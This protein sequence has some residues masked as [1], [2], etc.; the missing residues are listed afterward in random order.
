MIRIK[1]SVSCCD[2]K[3]KFFPTTW[4][5]IDEL[6]YKPKIFDWDGLEFYYDSDTIHGFIVPEDKNL[7]IDA[8]LRE[9]DI[10]VSDW[11]LERISTTP[12]PRYILNHYT[13][14]DTTYSVLV[15][16]E[17]DLVEGDWKLENE[18]TGLYF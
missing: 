13:R 11:N 16:S 2:S 7:D 4:P 10:S 14:G 12:D 17:S 6:K 3:F 1:P 5:L 18:Y 9:K 15:S 8:L